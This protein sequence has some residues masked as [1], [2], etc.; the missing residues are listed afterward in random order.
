MDESRVVSAGLGTGWTAYRHTFKGR[1][2]FWVGAMGMGVVGTA[3]EEGAESEG[4]NVS[5]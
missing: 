1:P 2:S 4:L 3:G 5:K